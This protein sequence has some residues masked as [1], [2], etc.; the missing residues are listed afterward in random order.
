MLDN[1]NVTQFKKHAAVVLVLHRNGSLTTACP[2]PV[3][4]FLAST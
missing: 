1:E 4:I 3:S 2:L